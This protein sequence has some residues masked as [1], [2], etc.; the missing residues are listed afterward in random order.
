L[1]PEPDFF[2]LGLAHYQ[3]GNWREAEENLRQFL[4]ND[5]RHGPSWHLLGAIAYQTEHFPLALENF[6]Q[7]VALEPANAGYL[8]CLGSAFHALQRFEEALTWHRRAQHLSP[9]EGQVLNN[10]GITLVAQGQT[11][12]A[13]T[14]F[15]Q[16]L[17]GNPH[18]AA[19]LCN[20]AAALNA[21][22]K[23]DEAI[24]LY[25]QAIELQPNLAQTHNNL[26]NAYQALGRLEQAAACFDR[27][28]QLWPGF[29]QAHHNK[30]LALQG[31][32]R[33][34]EARAC[35]QQAL[36]CH[37]DDHVVHSTYLGS[38]LYDPDVDAAT[39]LQEHQTWAKRHVQVAPKRMI[40]LDPDP[41]RVLR[42][43]YVSPDF[44]NHA[45]AY[46][47]EP[48]L[49][50]YDPSQ[51][52]V[53]CYAELINA[54]ERTAFFQRLVSSWRSTRGWTDEQLAGRIRQDNIDLL[55]DLA[56]HT[57][58][59]RLRVFGQQPAPIQISYLGYPA[60]TGLPSV[61]YRLVDS[62]TDPLGEPSRHSE[63]L[64]RLPGAFFCYAPPA[65][66][67]FEPEVAQKR[68][69]V[70]TFGSLHKLEKLNAAVLD[71]WCQVLTD[72][73]LARLL[74]ARDTLQGTT[75]AYWQRQFAARGVDVERIVFQRADP[76]GMRHLQVF[77]QI[78]IALDT[79]PWNG[80]T[81][82]CEALWMGV[83]VVALRG[84]RFAS[85][86]TASLLTAL[87]LTDLIA[88]SPKEFRRL[89]VALAVDAERRT[90]LHE[91]LR[92]RL[93]RS[94]VCNG[95]TFTRQ[96]EATLRLLW[97]R[98]CAEAR[99]SSGSN[100]SEAN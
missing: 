1:T 27:A 48:I 98:K 72:L 37:P 29:A 63:Q 2:S 24:V 61:D 4:Q 41:D 94:P 55:V 58:N 87:G 99:L 96:L 33:W 77:N 45:V 16:A 15:R 18:D 59:N 28:L 80:H 74:L 79:F 47:L 40:A 73:P 20:L 43:G 3:K 44:R 42:I 17:E 10:L 23:W 51:V 34:S 30:G 12:E 36:Q 35:F 82:A 19:G 91:T 62:I 93:L 100:P 64:V 78:D 14:V 90:H 89:A 32:S 31:Q 13:V 65:P 57:N 54:D 26:G 70:L 66:F 38:L 8:S 5:P 85:R 84:Q 88:E 86:M 68:Q 97:R 81:T 83:P 21:Q 75:M 56:G 67:P 69:G 71:L 9:R 50:Y 53:F 95:V 52:E 76:V 22:Q 11:E 46:F 25:L 49:R 6:Q 92:Q 60:T 7:A 39:L